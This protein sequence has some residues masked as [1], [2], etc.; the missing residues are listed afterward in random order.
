[1]PL[2]SPHIERRQGVHSHQRQRSFSAPNPLASEETWSTLTSPVMVIPPME[3]TQLSGTG[4]TWTFPVTALQT[5][6][7]S[8]REYQSAAMLQKS[9]EV[10]AGGSG[11]EMRMGREE[12]R[13]V[14][15]AGRD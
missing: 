13:D 8:A 12:E 1:M 5:P 9:H 15:M 7:H 11:G 6:A 3:S 4:T 14:G 10:E 2:S